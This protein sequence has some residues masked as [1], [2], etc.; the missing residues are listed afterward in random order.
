M[1]DEEYDFGFIAPP[2]DG[3]GVKVTVNQFR[4]QWYLHLREYIED[5]DEGIW[6]PTKKGIAVKAE[7]VDTIATMFADAG[8]LLRDI[9]VTGVKNLVSPAPTNSDEENAQ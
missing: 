6:F 8:E 4:N 2:V 1:S 7:D 9:Y 5:P 3:K